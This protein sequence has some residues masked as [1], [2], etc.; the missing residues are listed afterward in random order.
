MSVFIIA[1][2]G[3][4]HNGSLSVAKKLIDNAKKSGCD[5]IKFQSFL[6]NTR[7]SKFLKTEK[8]V[9]K[10]IGTQESIGEFFERCHRDTVGVVINRQGWFRNHANAGFDDE[11][12]VFLG[13]F[14][15]VGTISVEIDIRF[16]S[17]RRDN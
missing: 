10:I 2:A 3:L 11:A 7:V 9:E 1:E 14:D 13:D 6:P 8:Y 16:W 12:L 15:V 5:A 4:N 17:S